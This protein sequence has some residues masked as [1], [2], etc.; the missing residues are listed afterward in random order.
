MQITRICSDKE[1]NSYFD[2]TDIEMRAGG[3]LQHG[4]PKLSRAFPAKR[5]VLVESPPGWISA[6]S[7]SVR[8]Q[9]I[10]CLEGSVT[11]ITTDG[12]SKTFSEGDAWLQEDVEGLGHEA[13][14]STEKTSRLLVIQLE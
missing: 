14:G 11:I 5:Y 9:I 7:P 12:E 6:P 2:S 13:R 10:V 3:N 8:K 4:I 1:G